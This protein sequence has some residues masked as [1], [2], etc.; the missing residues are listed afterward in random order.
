MA[1]IEWQVLEDE[2]LPDVGDSEPRT[3]RRWPWRHVLL[4]LLVFILASSLGVWRWTHIQNARIRE[5]IARAV[6]GE[7]RAL[8]FGLSEQASE[9][10]DP[11]APDGWVER[12]R[13]SF[14]PQE[15]DWS[16]PEVVS[17]E[18]QYDVALVT[19]A[20]TSGDEVWQRVRAYRLVNNGW[21]R[22]PIP[23]D[24]W[25]EPEEYNSKHFSLWMASRD[26][27]AMPPEQ[28][29]TFLE[30]FRAEL[31]EVWH[32]QDDEP[33]TIRVQPFDLTGYTPRSARIGDDE[34]AFNSPLLVEEQAAASLT[35]SRAYQY[36]LAEQVSR[37]LIREIADTDDE[38]V[39]TLLLDALV[40]H[41][42][43]TEEERRQ[44][45]ALIMNRRDTAIPLT[46]ED[47]RQLSIP[48]HFSDYL[49]E[50]GGIDALDRFRML[51][52]QSNNPLTAFEVAFGRPFP[53]LVEEAWLWIEHG[54]GTGPREATGEQGSATLLTVLEEEPFRALAAVDE[55]RGL[56]ELSVTGEAD[57][58]LPARCLS[59]G[60]E[61]RFRRASQDETA[62]VATELDVEELRLPSLSYPPAPPGAQTLV[63]RREE[64]STRIV[65]LDS[66]GDETTLLALPQGVQLEVH[67]AEAS[68]AWLTEDECGTSVNQYLATHNHY[69][70]APVNLEGD[71]HLFW[72]EQLY[73]VD[74]ASQQKDDPH[75]T[76]SGVLPGTLGEPVE[77]TVRAEQQWGRLM[78][79]AFAGDQRL[80]ELQNGELQWFQLIRGL[81]GSGI[82]LLDFV[83][84]LPD[85]SKIWTI[86]PDGD[87]LAFTTPGEAPNSIVLW[88]LDVELG[89]YTLLH[90]APEGT[91]YGEMVWGHG[92][93]PTLL[94]SLGVESQ[95]E[96]FSNAL[97][98]FDMLQTI[99]ET[100]ISPQ[101]FYLDGIVSGL[102]WCPNDRL[103]YRLTRGDETL[104]VEGL[105]SDPPRP[106]L[107]LAPDDGG[108]PVTTGE[109]A[110]NLFQAEAPPDELTPDGQVIGCI[111]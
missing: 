15:G 70:R 95:G 85:D 97:L 19:L 59:R 63:A 11:Y 94:V 22:T 106:L 69:D 58:L 110:F 47:G 54:A 68:F 46:M 27:E 42:L 25:G 56:V 76:I 2:P 90:R 92:D 41:L 45:R 83:S 62:L 77:R 102:H 28:L 104:L 105:S 36:A 14:R 44:A 89:R 21:H 93:V 103:L 53:S 60:T 101:R 32:L 18:R 74:D 100:I 40:R 1:Q 67:P 108:V 64:D 81:D 84:P 78:G 37:A 79:H 111:G 30:K 9:L 3:R 31:A 24:W 72:A 10:A 34:F 88:V 65:A 107:A 50:M 4:A 75:W 86:S 66:Q 55:G 20:Y 91:A 23:A 98:G 49:I 12:Y 7:E 109:E 71:G 6:E 26:A 38:S 48:R 13:Q 51:L 96:V 5:D 33:L 73:V 99:R 43:L 39:A 87:W 29:L 16:A 57:L 80:L 52:E 61:L 35:P 17:V 82:I 8:R